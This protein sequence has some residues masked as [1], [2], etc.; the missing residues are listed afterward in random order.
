MNICFY[1]HG[2]N[3]HWSKKFFN[4]TVFVYTGNDDIDVYC[5]F[6]RLY[7]SEFF[8]SPRGYGLYDSGVW[9]CIDYS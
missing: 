6:L 9:G 2:G 8:I 4:D 7:V 3:I 1:L 5:D